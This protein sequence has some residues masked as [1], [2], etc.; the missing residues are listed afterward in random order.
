MKITV[1]TITDCKFSQAEKQYLQSRSLQFEERNLEANREYLT[2][3]L[4]ISN[5]FAGTPVTKIE[6]D[7]GQIIVL[8]GFTQDEFDKA[9]V[10]DPN[11]VKV[12]NTQV[13]DLQTGSVT[14]QVSVTIPPQSPIA[15]TQNPTPP[16]QAQQPVAQ[17]APPILQPVQSQ[18]PVPPAPQPIMAQPD[19]MQPPAVPQAMSMP[20]QPMS[21]P[22][23]AQPTY[24]SLDMTAPQP[25]QPQQ[26]PPAPPQEDQA[27]NSLLQNLQNRVGDANT[28]Q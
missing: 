18:Q 3:M 7:D 12:Q 19:F 20:P 15:E 17:V 16:V 25:P 24:P 2:E 14:Q 5:N 9:L 22:Q 6:K 10:I 28:N 13:K 26:M 23:T 4:N 27:L 1:Y 8:K 11:A 21:P